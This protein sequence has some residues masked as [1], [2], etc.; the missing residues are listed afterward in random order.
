MH[1]GLRS[2][3]R[4]IPWVEQVERKRANGKTRIVVGEY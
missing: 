3:K 4:Y 1:E 2:M